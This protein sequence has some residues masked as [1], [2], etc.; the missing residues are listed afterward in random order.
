MAATVRVGLAYGAGDRAGIS[1]AGWTSFALAMAFACVTATLLLTLPRPLVGIF[2]DMSG[3][4]NQ[5]VIALALAF[6]FFAGLFQFVDAAQAVLNGMLR[7]L[8][9]TRAP[10][11][12]C[13]IGYWVVGLPLGVALA[14]PGGLGGSGIWIGLA[15]G[16]ASVAVMLLVRWMMR[17]G[18]SLARAPNSAAHAMPEG[19]PRHAAAI[20]PAPA[21]AAATVKEPT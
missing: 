8:G 13:A 5:A 18:L 14:F 4:E 11:I 12:I 7:G 1:R 15:V 2:L 20:G 3:A 21:A 19:P 16:L 9:D 6:V 17:D 10:M